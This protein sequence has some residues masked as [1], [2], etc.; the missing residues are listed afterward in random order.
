MLELVGRRHFN[1]S[2][3]LITRRLAPNGVALVHSI[4]VYHNAKRFNHW[5]NKYIFPG[6]Y[7]ALL[8]QMVRAVGRLGPKIFD[9]KIMREHC[10]ETLE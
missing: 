8:E 1:I 3:G 4:R 2:Y 7:I 10:D 6:D 9:M 5:L